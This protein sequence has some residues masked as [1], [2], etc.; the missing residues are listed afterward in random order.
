M[1]AQKHRAQV[2]IRKAATRIAR[3]NEKEARAREAIRTT[4]EE[5]TREQLCRIWAE[6]SALYGISQDRDQRAAAIVVLEAID[7]EIQ[8]RAPEAWARWKKS[9]DKEPNKYIL[10]I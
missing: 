4:L 6:T 5:S 7:D 9:L 2:D 3:A 1:K 10:T 8:D